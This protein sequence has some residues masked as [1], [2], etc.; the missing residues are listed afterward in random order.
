METVEFGAIYN[1]YNPNPPVEE[2]FKAG[3]NDSCR[4][5]ELFIVKNLSH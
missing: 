2:A 5:V 4:S 1:K 3:I